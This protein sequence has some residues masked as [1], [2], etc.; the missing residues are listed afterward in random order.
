MF[1]E[2]TQKQVSITISVGQSQLKVLE[3]S[4]RRITRKAFLVTMVYYFYYHA[5]DDGTTSYYSKF[6]CSS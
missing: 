5:N 4:E 6:F 1:L 3:G 2:K